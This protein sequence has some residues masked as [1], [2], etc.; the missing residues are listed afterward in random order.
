MTGELIYCKKWSFG[1]KGPFCLMSEG[2]AR[3]AH[4]NGQEYCAL[5]GPQN[6]PTHAI[7]LNPKTRYVGVTFF[8][9]MLRPELDFSYILSATGMLEFN[10]ATL[11]HYADDSDEPLFYIAHVYRPNGETSVV[12]SY[13]GGNREARVVQFAP[14]RRDLIW[15]KF[16]EY[17][18]LLD[19][20][21]TSWEI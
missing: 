5:H 3:T 6:H 1:R 14:P 18:E 13:K 2:K 9:T 10:D 17:A 12:K 16:G 8:D 19:N 11:R 15:P 21:I 4:A 7:T 20:T